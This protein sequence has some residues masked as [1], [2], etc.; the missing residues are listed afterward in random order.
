MELLQG[1]RSPSPTLSREEADQVV[2]QAM[3]QSQ[4]TTTRRYLRLFRWLLIAIGIWCLLSLIPHLFLLAILFRPF[5][6]ASIGAIGGADG[7]TAILVATAPAA[8][9]N[10]FSAALSLVVLILCIIL[11]I[12]VRKLERSLQ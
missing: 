4:R 6:A 7:P 2:A 12:R 5:T 10:W 8:F 3:A 1:E 11:A 9:P